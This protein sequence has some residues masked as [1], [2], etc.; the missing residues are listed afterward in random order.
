[1]AK[2]NKNHEVPLDLYDHRTLVN[3]MLL[4]IVDYEI[5]RIDSY[6]DK[7]S[8][9]MYADYFRILNILR[10]GCT[11]VNPSALFSE[12]VFTKDNS[13]NAFRC[14]YDHFI[15]FQCSVDDDIKDIR[16]SIHDGMM[17]IAKE[18][19]I[20]KFDPDELMDTMNTLLWEIDKYSVKS[21]KQVDKFALRISEKAI[22]LIRFWN[23][24][25]ITYPTIIDPYK[26]DPRRMERMN[27][28]LGKVKKDLMLANSK[29][30]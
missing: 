25:T 9:D 19:L 16:K 10:R 3:Y 18:Y 20:N 1:M 13:V 8:E 24:S 12:C 4:G 2:K 23:A 6:I 15:A 29:K 11:S 28:R 27:S 30:K 7:A 17:S 5:K 22:D 14:T 26:V 21:M